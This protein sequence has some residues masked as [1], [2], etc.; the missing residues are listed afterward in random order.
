MNPWEIMEKMS[1]KEREDFARVVNKLLGSTF[2]TRRN[3]ENKRD[4]YFIERYEELLREYLKNA[5]WT[6]VG[7]RIYGIFQ[8]VS[9]FPANRL[10]L[11]LEESIILLIIRLCYEEKRKEVNLTENICLRVREIQDKY[12]ALKIRARPIDKK[13]LREAVNLFKRFNLLTALDSDVTD[14]ECRLE[15]YPTI[16]FAT[17]VDDVRSL[18]DKLESYGSA[19][20]AGEDGE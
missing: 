2:I 11:R 14:P 6:L 8:A 16:L 5:G 18:Y 17:R 13:S 10:H 7:D 1:V 12:A 20:P 9:D 19:R 3:E 15:V 4:Y